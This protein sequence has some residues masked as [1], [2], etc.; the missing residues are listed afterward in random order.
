MQITWRLAGFTESLLN[1]CVV[2]SVLRVV[3]KILSNFW[4]L[5]GWNDNTGWAV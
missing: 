4:I 3:L 1:K 2:V 5:I